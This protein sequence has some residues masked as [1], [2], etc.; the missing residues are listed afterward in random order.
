MH[1]IVAYLGELETACLRMSLKSF[2]FNTVS[3]LN[4]KLTTIALFLDIKK[5]FDT[6][7][8]KRLK[9]VKLNFPTYLIKLISDYL[10]ERTL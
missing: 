8:I 4:K 2:L 5:A 9:L 1:L 6:V 3:G 7:W 10:Y